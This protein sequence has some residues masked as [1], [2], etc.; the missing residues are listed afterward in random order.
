MRKRNVPKV[1]FSDVVIAIEYN[2]IILYLNY[3]FI[4]I[5]FIFRSH[6]FS[7]RLIGTMHLVFGASWLLKCSG[8]GRPRGA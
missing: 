2:I 3:N 7:G 1:K 4:N 6:T 5:R 8:G